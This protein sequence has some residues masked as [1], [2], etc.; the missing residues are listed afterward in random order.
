MSDFRQD[1]ALIIGVHN[2]IRQNLYP[3]QGEKA[4]LVNEN[5][6]LRLQ[7]LL[8]AHGIDGTGPDIDGKPSSG[9][10]AVK[11]L[12][13]LRNLIMH[14]DHGKFKICEGSPNWKAFDAFAGKHPE[15]KVDEGEPICLAGKEVLEPLL[16]GLMDWAKEK[17]V[18][19]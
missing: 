4:H 15:I 17:E 7:A 6:I 9:E 3:G 14:K 1:L 2:E 11:T 12:K 16:K 10:I 13:Y 5:T 19:K 18:I 8:E